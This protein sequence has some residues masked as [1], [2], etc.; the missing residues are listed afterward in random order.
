MFQQLHED[1]KRQAGY[2]DMEIA[3]K[4]EAI[5]NV[6]VPDTLDMHI[7]RL[8]SCG[9]RIVTPWLQTYNFVSILAQK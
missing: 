1:F 6:L 3:A 8:H 9:F 4:R 5:D 7:D 2:T